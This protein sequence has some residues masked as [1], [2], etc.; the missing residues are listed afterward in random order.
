[1]AG[2]RLSAPAA[3]PPAPGPASP[4]PPDGGAP[5]PPRP[6]PS[7][8]PGARERTT[9][10]WVLLLALIGGAVLLRTLQWTSAP[11]LHTTMEVIATTL[12]FVVGGV[13]LVRYYS[14]KQSTYL[15]IG[16]GFVGTALLELNH[17]LVTSPLYALPAGVA[18]QDLSAWSWT[19]SRSYLS[20]YLFV[21]L[22][23]W[24]R[25]TRR[26]CR[27]VRILETRREEWRRS[28]PHRR[29]TRRQS[30]CSWPPLMHRR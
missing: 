28:F 22:L 6:R 17:A 21:S 11:I 20:L 12:A 1:M 15:F 23:A 24:W 25:E 29:S 4:S 30:R 9:V 14:R 7:S 3:P 19:A 18:A 2:P 16:T 8:G 13:S 26:A 27:A 10:Y 5:I